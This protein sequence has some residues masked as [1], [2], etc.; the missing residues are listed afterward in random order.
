MKHLDALVR[1]C[2]V[3]VTGRFVRQDIANTW[4]VIDWVSRCVDSGETAPTD[5]DVGLNVFVVDSLHR[6]IVSFGGFHGIL[7]VVFVVPEDEI[8]LAF[9][10]CHRFRPSVHGGPVDKFIKANALAASDAVVD[11][12]RIRR[13]PGKANIAFQ[14]QDLVPTMVQRL[15]PE[16]VVLALAGQRQACLGR[17]AEFGFSV[18]V[19][20]GGSVR[21]HRWKEFHVGSI[22]DLS[23]LSEGKARECDDEG[24]AQQGAAAMADGA[25]RLHHHRRRLIL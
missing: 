15:D 23:A 22:L 13:R 14:L 4:V 12:D 7:V 6:T 11:A 16:A 1:G 2:A 17:G 24:N 18:N 8:G 19:F 21:L 10:R 20:V 25:R 5:C 3:G 9:C